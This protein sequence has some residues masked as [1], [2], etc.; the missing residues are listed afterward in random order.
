[1]LAA[2]AAREG[3]C[4]KCV[5]AVPS[6]LLLAGEA[7]TIVGRIRWDRSFRSGRAQSTSILVGEEI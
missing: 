2:V 6:L 3:G 1:V 4:R 5:I 7:W